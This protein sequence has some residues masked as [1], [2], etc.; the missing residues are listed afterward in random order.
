MKAQIT[1]SGQINGNFKLKSAIACNG[2]YTNIISGMFN[3]F[4]IN[5]D[6]VG[7]AKKALR[8]AWKQIK[9]ENENIFWHDGLSKDC[10]NLSYDAS[11]ARL[12]KIGF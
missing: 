7:E 6:T 4:H 1:I 2:N 5:F 11:Q 8:K 3:S 12:N 9:S 10:T